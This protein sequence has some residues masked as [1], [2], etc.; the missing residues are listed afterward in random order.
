MTLIKNKIMEAPK[1]IYL[2]ICGDCN[3][4]DCKNCNFQDLENNVTWCVDKIF[5]KDFEYIKADAFIE[6]AWNWVED[7]ILSS[8]Q[9]DK[10]RSYY[11]QFRNYIKGE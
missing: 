7:N 4:D 5:D 11:E 8:N 6:K 1:K 2:Q 10:S 3:D 9:Q